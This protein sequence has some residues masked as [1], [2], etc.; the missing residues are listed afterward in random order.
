[1]AT[2]IGKYWVTK[3]AITVGAE[4]LECLGGNGYVEE[5]P[6]ARLYRDVPLDSIWEGSGNV[7]CLDVLRALHKEPE[8]GKALFA[9]L[10]SA[11]GIDV[12]YDQFLSR[13]EQELS[14]VSESEVRARRIVE[15]LGLALQ[16]A[17]LLKHGDT[18]S[19]MLSVVAA[20]VGRNLWHSRRQPTD[21]TIERSKPLATNH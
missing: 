7:Q 19:G 9:E 10:N 4:A 8:T 14:D 5:A 15:T 12:Q 16:A 21:A 18:A 13:T 11:K 6:L 3:R 1:M 20:G 17:M 2:A